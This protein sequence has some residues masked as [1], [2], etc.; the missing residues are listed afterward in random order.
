MQSRLMAEVRIMQQ[1]GCELAFL[2]QRQAIQAGDRLPQLQERTVRLE[3]ME[4]AGRGKDSSSGDGPQYNNINESGGVQN[5]ANNSNT[6][7][8]GPV[9]FGQSQT[10][11]GQSTV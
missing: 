9:Y 6:G 10:S 3:E 11:Q 5:V 8:L 1:I 2:Q 4:K 7:S